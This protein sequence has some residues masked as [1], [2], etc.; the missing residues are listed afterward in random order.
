MSDR[1]TRKFK[2]WR[3][4]YDAGFNTCRRREVELHTGLTVLVGCNGAGKSTLLHNI[5]SELNKTK[6][7]YL[8]LDNSSGRDRN[9]LMGSA[10]FHGDYELASTSMCSSEG[11][12][13]TIGLSRFASKIRK[14]LISREF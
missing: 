11:E 1:A 6:T 8:M 4:P 2:M 9:D 5:E 10:I 13:I 3:D 12:N 7:P 14:F